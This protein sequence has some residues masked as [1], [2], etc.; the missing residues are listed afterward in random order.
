MSVTV[1]LSK[2]VYKQKVYRRVLKPCER[3]FC[4]HLLFMMVNFTKHQYILIY[5]TVSLLSHE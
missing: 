5:K 2:K 1:Y 4:F 3:F